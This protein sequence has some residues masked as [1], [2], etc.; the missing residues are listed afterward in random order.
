M[1][2]VLCACRAG[3]LSVACLRVDGELCCAA[4]SSGTCV[5]AR[6][7]GKASKHIMRGKRRW[8]M[9]VICVC[10]GACVCVCVCVCAYRYRALSLLFCFFVLLVF[11]LFVLL[12]WRLTCLVWG[13]SSFFAPLTLS[14]QMKL[15]L[16]LPSLAGTVLA[17]KDPPVAPPCYGVALYECI[18]G[19]S[20]VGVGF[21][22][23]YGTS[24]GVG[25]QVS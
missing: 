1:F 9:H 13:C 8:P 21:D 18:P 24:R 15:L 20:A 3:V 11:L 17:I 12:A 16:L 6:G 4:L 14:L 2:V 19:L 22:A 10:V 23:V 7:C 25:K 5:A